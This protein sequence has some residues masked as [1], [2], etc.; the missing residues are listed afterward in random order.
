MRCFIFI[1]ILGF[2]T[3][4]K[5]KKTGSV[6]ASINEKVLLM[7]TDKAFSALSVDKG[8]KTAFVEYI[9][10][11]GILLKPGKMPI[12]GAHAIDYLI[13]QDDTSFELN[14]QPYNAMVAAS[15][16]LGFTYGVYALHPANIDTVLYGTYVTIWKKQ[17]NGTWKFVLDSGNEGID[18]SAVDNF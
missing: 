6:D 4:C 17:A 10:S 1:L 8:M 2:T 15:A 9:D 11:N 5:E 18:R 13:Q 12:I 3:G 7:Q 14:W 16:D